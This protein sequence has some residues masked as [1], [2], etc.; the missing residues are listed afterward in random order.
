MKKEIRP[1]SFLKL[2]IFTTAVVVGAG[3]LAMYRDEIPYL[4]NMHGPELEVSLFQAILGVE[5][6]GGLG[7]EKQKADR[8]TRI[9]WLL[10]INPKDPLTLLASEIPGLQGYRGVFFDGGEDLNYSD[11]PMESHPTPE[12]WAKAESDAILPDEAPKTVVITSKNQSAPTVYI[13]HTHNR[14]SWISEVKGAKTDSEAMSSSRNI[15]LVGETFAEALKQVGISAI[16][17]QT[18]IYALLKK[19]GKPYSLSYARSMEIVETAKREHQTLNYF[20]DFHRDA[21]GREKTTAKI[22]GVDYAKIMFVVGKGNK[23]WKENLKFAESLQKKL[24]EQYPAIT[25]PI[26]GYEKSTGHNGEY[27]QSISSHA[28]TVEI[29]GIGNNVEESKRSAVA[30]A[31]VFAELYYEDAVPVVEPIVEGKKNG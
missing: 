3:F 12:M 21:I 13:Y 9:S 16:H 18:D 19:E 24:E 22:N 7:E 2:M 23:N 1:K 31:H 6:P 28:I 10:G 14:E 26:V 17:D 20:F 30:L 27:N 25:R 29:G 5:I 8:A 15:T 11:L 4:K